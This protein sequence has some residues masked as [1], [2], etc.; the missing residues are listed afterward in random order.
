LRPGDG[1]VT[2]PF[3]RGL[4]MKATTLLEH[5]HRNLR[6]LCD[7]VEMGSAAMRVSLLPQLAGD[8]AAHIAVEEQV[9]YPVACAALHDDDW[10]ETFRARRLQAQQSLDR[11]LHASPEGEEFTRAIE[12]LSGLMSKHA[13]EEEHDL[14]PRL[15]KALDAQAMR[16]LGESM[17]ALYEREVESGYSVGC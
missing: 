2:I 14:F 1:A 3:P 10:L 5:Q 8:L 16:A 7:A 12:E 6:E 13:A 11:A 4:K 9:F 17:R 15:E